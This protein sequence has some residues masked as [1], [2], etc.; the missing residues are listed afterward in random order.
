METISIMP[1]MDWNLIKFS[2]RLA[3]S[4]SSLKLDVFPRTAGHSGDFKPIKQVVRRG[5][6]ELGRCHVS[7]HQ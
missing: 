2:L 7:I 3:M 1:M 5:I 4:L 6:L